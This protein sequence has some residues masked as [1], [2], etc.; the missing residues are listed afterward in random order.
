MNYHHIYNSV[1]SSRD[2]SDNLEL[3]FYNLPQS[4]ELLFNFVSVKT[5]KT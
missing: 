5:L 3:G 1:S 4:N 2:I